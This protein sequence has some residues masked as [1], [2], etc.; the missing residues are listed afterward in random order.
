MRNPLR[1]AAPLCLTIAGL[2]ACTGETMPDSGDDVSDEVIDA[3]SSDLNVEQPVVRET[4][5][6]VDANGAKSADT[7][8]PTIGADAVSGEVGSGAEAP[9]PPGG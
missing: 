3:T 2:T 8:Q 5:L 9:N 4:P 7:E 6:P 1:Y